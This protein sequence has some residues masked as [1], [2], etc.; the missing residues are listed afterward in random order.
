VNVAI[1]RI[2][3]NGYTPKELKKF[4]KGDPEIRLY[5]SNDAAFLPIRATAKVTLGELS[6]TMVEKR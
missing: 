2:P 4:K 6:L 1:A 3:I 5:F